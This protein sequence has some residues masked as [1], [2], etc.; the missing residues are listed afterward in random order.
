M[1]KGDGNTNFMESMRRLTAN[2]WSSIKRIYRFGSMSGTKRWTIYSEIFQCFG[3]IG[4]ETERKS[5]KK[6]NDDRNLKLELNANEMRCN[7][8]YG[9]LS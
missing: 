5:T 4:T 9:D 6:V 2:Y 7:N 8:F 3:S 1:D